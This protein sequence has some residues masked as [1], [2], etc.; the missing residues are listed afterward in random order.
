MNHKTYTFKE[1]QKSI[2]TLTEKMELIKLQRS[3]LTKNINTLNKQIKNWQ[4]LDQ[5]QFK[6]FDE[7][8]EQPI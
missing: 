4:E 2:D 1:V 6:M 8:T 3:E 5:S 7:K